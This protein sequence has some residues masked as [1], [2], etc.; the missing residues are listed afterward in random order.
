VWVT[1]RGVF[2]DRI[3]SAWL[4]RRFID[5]KARFKFVAGPRYAARPGEIR[6]DMFQA[7]YTHRG[8]WCTFE[9]LLHEF[10]LTHPALHAIGEIVHDI[11]LKDARFERPETEGIQL[12]LQGLVR[13]QADDARRLKAGGQVFYSLFAQLSVT[14]P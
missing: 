11:D 8:D 12:L 6:F 14:A 10:R 13:A 5:P 3:A 7:E 9:T 4:I 2:V 1:R